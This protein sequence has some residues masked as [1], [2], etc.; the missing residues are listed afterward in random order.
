MNA[1][2][3]LGRKCEEEGDFLLFELGLQPSDYDNLT[4]DRANSLYIKYVNKLKRIKAIASQ[5]SK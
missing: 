1:D 2:V 4:I 3:S 5:N